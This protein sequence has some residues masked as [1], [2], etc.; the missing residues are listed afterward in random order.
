MTDSLSMSPPDPSTDEWLTPQQA[1]ALVGI[2]ADTIRKW[3]NSGV[4]PSQRVRPGSHRRFLRSDVMA[5][6]AAA[7]QPRQSST[8]Q[9]A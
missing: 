9:S 6:L 1:A 5:L 3:A 4:L 7:D 8:A 2:T